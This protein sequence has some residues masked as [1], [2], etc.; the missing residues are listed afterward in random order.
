MDSLKNFF[1]L[2]AMDNEVDRQI[3]Q[4]LRG[5][6][7]FF[8]GI[9]LLYVALSSLTD[10]QR[11]GRYAAQ[12][13]ILLSCMLLG[14]FF[15]R[16]GYARSAAIFATLVIW[17]VFTVAAYTGGGVRSSGYFGYLVVLVVAGVL[18]GKRFDTLLVTLLCIG[19][20]YYMVYAEMNGTLPRPAVPMTAFALWLDSLFFFAVVAG[21]LFMTMRV[22]FSA[23]QRLNHELFERK[24]AEQKAAQSA[25]QLATLNEIARA[26]SEVTDLGAV[27]EIIRQQLEKLLEFDFYSVRVFHAETRMVTYLAVYESGRYWDEADA[28]LIPGT[29]TCEVFETGKSVLRLYRE[30]EL[31]TIKS[32][33]HRVGD[34]N[35]YTSSV[36]FVPLKKQGQTIGLLTMQRYAFNAYTEEHLRLVESVAIQVAI[37]IENARL[38]ARLQ[39]ELAERKQAEEL[40][41]KV[42]FELQRRLKELYALN[43]AAQA[44][45]SAKDEGELLEAVVETLY[46]SLYPDIVGVAFWDEQEGVLRTIPRAHRGIPE[47]VDR[48]VFRPGQ[49][50]VGHVA[51]TRQSYRM[52]N[53]DDPFYLSIDPF[54]RSELCVPI[55]AGEKLL[56]VLDIE[57]REP[58]AFSDADENLL[59][60]VAG[61]LAAA[62]ERLRAEQQLRA[63]NADLEQRVSERTAQLQAANKELEAF[64]YS[65]SH[66]LRAPLRS[67]NG[68][69]KIL[70]E[71]FSGDLPLSARQF[72][73][74]IVNAGSQMARLIDELLSFSRLGRNPL[75]LQATDVNET[76]Q[77]VIESLVPET[78]GRQIE[79]VLAE[80]PP[81]TVDPSLLRLVY[82]NLIGNAVKYT[83]TRQAARIEI[84]SFTKNGEIVYFVRD[85]GVGFDMQYA[86]KLF[87]V[88]QRLHRDDEFEGTGIGLATVQRIINR[89]GGRVWA[90]AAVDRGATLFFTLGRE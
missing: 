9:S 89:H 36:I 39:S 59:V 82:T 57:S 51:A 33:L 88:F 79:W 24:Q 73:D 90:E 4:V 21:L 27:L 10:F 15:L 14:L 70:D 86:G 77:I 40:T 32:S 49:G 61:Q 12:G 6:L 52:R 26:V 45:A 41:R 5:V 66:D 87:G 3:A 35:R 72:L 47:S 85:N 17:L 76:V 13:G 22:T 30:D 62:L 63:L 56:G 64:S 25:S 46:R 34:R 43:A 55:L 20:G 48:M 16:K 2:P 74:K 54:I 29:E 42:N 1:A 7:V 53:L 31:E 23:L 75:S 81:A 58:D 44:G 38:F 80:M 37:A 11:W 50:I 8:G 28:P 68:F 69:A 60:T 83:G 67:I 19:A 65:V 71:D 84:G 18:S 78:R